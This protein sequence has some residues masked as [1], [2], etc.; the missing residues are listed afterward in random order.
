MASNVIIV[1]LRQISIKTNALACGLIRVC[2]PVCTVASVF[3]LAVIIKFLRILCF[4]KLYSP[5]RARDWKKS[6]VPMLINRESSLVLV[7][8]FCLNRKAKRNHGMPTLKTR[9]K[10]RATRYRGG[11]YVS[12]I[13]F[14]ECLSMLFIG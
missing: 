7:C 14:N 1:C 10:G 11:G 12:N 6:F 9:F 5:C 4:S 3:C 2:L 8:R 13:Q